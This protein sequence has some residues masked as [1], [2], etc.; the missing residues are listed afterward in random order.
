MP[1]QQSSVNSFWY[2]CAFKEFKFIMCIMSTSRLPG[3][4]CNVLSNEAP[5]NLLRDVIKLET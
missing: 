4:I 1:F 2:Y 5:G 3:I